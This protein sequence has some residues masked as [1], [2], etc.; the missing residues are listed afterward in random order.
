MVRN[1]WNPFTGIYSPVP[2]EEIV[3]EKAEKANA[4]AKARPCKGARFHRH[5]GNAYMV[6][7]AFSFSCA[8]LTLGA[9]T[10]VVA[11][12]VALFGIE[13]GYSVW[14]ASRHYRVIRVGCHSDG[15]PVL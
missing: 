8:V 15:R 12:G 10:E 11:A 5:A 4:K 6:V 2:E 7:A 9:P 14:M 1:T 13:G 3:R